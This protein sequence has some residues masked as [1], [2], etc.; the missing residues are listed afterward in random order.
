MKSNKI[1]L[2]ALFGTSLNTREGAID[3]SN[4]ISAL[5]VPL[6]ELDFKEVEFMS[7]SFADQFYKEKLKLQENHISVYVKNAN[8]EIESI[9]NTV[10]NTQNKKD[11]TFNEIQ[12]IRFKS[13]NEM[14]NFL[15][16]R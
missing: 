15:L 14:S 12:V 5:N 10:S 3:L 16:S 1:D 8:Q 7:R 13:V 2:K 11:R 4:L 6:V 9:L